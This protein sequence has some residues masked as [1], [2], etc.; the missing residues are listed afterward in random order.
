[1]E[2]RK[3]DV[4]DCEETEENGKSHGCGEGGVVEVERAA[5]GWW[6]VAIRTRNGGGTLHCGSS[7][8]WS[9]S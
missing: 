7:A 5:R 3:E 8:R 9:C 6:Y 4:H 2:Y 1:M